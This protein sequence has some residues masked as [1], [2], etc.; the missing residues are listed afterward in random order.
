MDDGA[1]GRVGGEGAVEV[2]EDRLV[3]GRGKVG[4]RGRVRG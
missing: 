4:V 1:V 3:R 2:G